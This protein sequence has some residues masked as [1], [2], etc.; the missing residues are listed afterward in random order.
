MRKDW[1]ESEINFLIEYYPDNGRNYC[2][3]VLNRTIESVRRKA[4]T[5]GIKLRKEAR[6]R[7]S[8]QGT[9]YANKAR[10]KDRIGEKSINFQGYEMVVIESNGAHKLTIKFNDER[11]SIRNNISYQ[12]FINGSVKNL[13]HLDVFNIG[14][15]GEGIHTARVGGKMSK[16]Y[17]MWVNM[18]SRCYNEV[19]PKRQNSYKGV[20]VCEEWHNFQVFAEW[21]YKNYNH[22]IMEKWALDK[23]LL[24]FS[25][26]KYSNT[27]CLLLPSEI[28]SIF[29]NQLLNKSTGVRG[30]YKEGNKYVANISKFGKQKYL[31]IFDT[32][33]EAANVYLIAKKDYLQEVSDKWRGILSNKVC[34]IIRDF[35][36]NLL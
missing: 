1:T 8:K 17:N 5:M 31:G 23:D 36:V 25:C 13:Y 9:E 30:V 7:I 22:K 35:D 34:D 4:E 27:T 2:G 20:T 12:E 21:F 24:C 15:F 32:I 3:V 16:C 28:N 18:L 33:E 11:G 10:I 6:S 29:Q 14:Y 26:R 19:N